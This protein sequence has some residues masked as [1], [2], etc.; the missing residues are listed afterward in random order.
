MM[1]GRDF[2]GSTS[3]TTWMDDVSWWLSI[4]GREMMTCCRGW[5]RTK[6]T[7]FRVCES[8]LGFLSW[9]RRRWIVNHVF[10]G[11][12][13]E[14][15][16]NIIIIIFL[17]FFTYSFSKTIPKPFLFSF[18]TNQISFLSSFSLLPKIISNISFS[19]IAFTFIFQKT[20]YIFL[21]NY[22]IREYNYS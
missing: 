6:A 14:N 5:R 18:N 7:T 15:N 4:G 9:G 20:I 8:E 10:Q 3:M 13:K 1:R 22:I 19:S 2:D 11:L 17:F 16:K 21:N 12:F